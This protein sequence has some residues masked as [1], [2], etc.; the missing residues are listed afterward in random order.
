MARATP[1]PP[2]GT[3]FAS[4]PDAQWRTFWLRCNSCHGRKTHG[5]PLPS[6]PRNS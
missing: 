6:F 4:Q 5:P 2:L 3:R 1:L